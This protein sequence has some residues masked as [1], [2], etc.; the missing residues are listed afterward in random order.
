MSL[1]AIIDKKMFVYIMEKSMS[2][3]RRILC[4]L[5]S[6]LMLATL[7]VAGGVAPGEEAPQQPEI[8]EK[9]TR[10][11]AQTSAAVSKARQAV[12][13]VLFPL[14]PK[15]QLKLI[16]TIGCLVPVKE[17]ALRSP[18]PVPRRGA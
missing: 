17:S 2:K 3:M 8:A 10:T 14:S 9:V 7:A 6:L 4:P 1:D 18:V 12:A 13:E 11:P 5:L 16:K 15:R